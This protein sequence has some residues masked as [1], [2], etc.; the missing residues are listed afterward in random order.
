LDEERLLQEIET[1]PQKFAEVYEAFY[2]N[3]FGYVFRRTTNYDAAKDIAAETFLKAFAGIGKFRWRNISILH[4][5]YRIA[6]NETYK[7]FKSRKY[8]PESINRIREEYDIDIT[9]YSNAETERIQLE[10]ELQ[11]SR[12]STNGTGLSIPIHWSKRKV[13]REPCRGIC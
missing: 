8:Q 12:T 13:L 5:L 11:R 9:D 10:E 3:I 4:W 2:T 7:Y 6:T 1:D